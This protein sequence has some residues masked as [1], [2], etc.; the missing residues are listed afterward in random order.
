[1]IARRPISLMAMP[2]ASSAPVAATGTTPETRS[3]WRVAHSSAWKPPIEPPMAT[4]LRDA[5]SLDQRALGVDDVADRDQG[6]AHGVGAAGERIDRRPVR[7]CPGSRRGC[8][9][10]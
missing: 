5:E 3:G 9:R 7:W 4:S 1:M 10:R 8:W 2:C 6:E